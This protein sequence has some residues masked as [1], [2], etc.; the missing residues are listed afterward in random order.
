MCVLEGKD[1]G[2]FTLLLKVEGKTCLKGVSLRIGGERGGNEQCKVPQKF[3]DSLDTWKEWPRRRAVSPTVTAGR[4][5]QVG[6]C[7]WAGS[8]VRVAAHASRYHLMRAF[9]Q[10]V[11]VPCLEVFLV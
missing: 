6:I 1:L 4:G 8:E 7:E 11:Q 3:P 5:R 2:V 9:P 10:R